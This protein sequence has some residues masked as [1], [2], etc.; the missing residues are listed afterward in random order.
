MTPCEGA[1]SLIDIGAERATE[2]RIDL[3]NIVEAAAD[4]ADNA[5]TKKR[6]EGHIDGPS[7]SDV[8]K[9][10]RHERVARFKPADAV[11]FSIPAT[12]IPNRARPRT[13]SSLDYRSR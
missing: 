13:A 2:I 5:V 10:F 9:I 7:A 12:S 3:G 1:R 8:E 11:K 4:A 6:R